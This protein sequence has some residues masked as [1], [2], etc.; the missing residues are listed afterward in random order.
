MDKVVDHLLV[1]KGQAEIQDF[2]GNYTQF[3][4]AIKNDELKIKG[5]VG[6]NLRVRPTANT[7]HR[8]DGKPKLSFKEKRELEALEQEIADLEAEQ[9]LL[10]QALSTGTLSN[11]E[12]LQK[13]QRI[14]QVINDLDEKSMRWLELSEKEG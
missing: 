4:E 11:D 3:R 14:Q 12:L 6:A 5:N 8:N 2:P 10:E 9:S 1:F 13:S 7:A